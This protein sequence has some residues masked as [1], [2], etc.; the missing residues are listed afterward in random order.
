MSGDRHPVRPMR[1]WGDSLAR[2]GDR[3]AGHLPAWRRVDREK[4]V[5]FEPDPKKPLREPWAMWFHEVWLEFM[6]VLD[7]DSERDHFLT[8]EEALDYG[9]VDEV[10]SPPEPGDKN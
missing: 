3:C 4:A 2:S 5:G 8:A 6:P 7:A 10:L 1:L 9:V